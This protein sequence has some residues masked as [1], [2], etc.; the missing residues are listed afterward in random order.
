MPDYSPGT[1]GRR[2]GGQGWVVRGRVG[3]ERGKGGREKERRGQGRRGEEGG[4]VGG[5]KK[6][7]S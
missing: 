4:G 2:T 3:D 6:H 5:E 7:I 1:T